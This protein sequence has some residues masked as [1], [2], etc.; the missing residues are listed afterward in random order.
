VDPDKREKMLLTWERKILRKIYG[1][2]KEN[3]LWRM[4]TNAELRNKYKTEDIVN[5][6]KT[7][8]LEWVGHVV[9][10]DGTIGVKK[11]FE[12]HIEGK[13]EEGDVN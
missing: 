12:G 10:M 2:T 1:P 8:R 11:I 6:I 13:N 4:K 7:K 9:R 5:V 3:G